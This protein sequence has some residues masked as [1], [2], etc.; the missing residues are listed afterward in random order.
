MDLILCYF[1]SILDMGMDRSLAHTCSILIYLAYISFGD[2]DSYL[3]LRTK[4][5]FGKGVSGKRIEIHESLN[6]CLLAF[7]HDSL[8]PFLILGLSI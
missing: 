1:S 4:R 2:M 6:D 5:E 7:F 3:S 8:F